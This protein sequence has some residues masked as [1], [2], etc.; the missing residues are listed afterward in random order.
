L[1]LH[2]IKHHDIEDVWGRGDKDIYIY[3]YI[4]FFF[5]ASAVNGDEWLASR[6]YRF[7]LKG[8]GHARYTLTVSWT[9]TRAGLD[10]VEE[11]RFY[12]CVASNAKLP[13]PSYRDYAAQTPE[14]KGI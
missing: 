2:V 10:T 11:E 13:A 4:I 5:F 14:G 7:P 8:K 9:G 12:I 1:P 3:I 6:L